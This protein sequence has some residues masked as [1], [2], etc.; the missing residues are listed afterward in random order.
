MKNLQ[1]IFA[2]SGWAVFIYAG[3]RFHEIFGFFLLGFW[4]FAIS[5]VFKEKTK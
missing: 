4:L 5:A 1:R 2:V 3:F